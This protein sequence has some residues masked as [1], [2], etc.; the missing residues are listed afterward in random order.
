MQVL[1][2]NPQKGLDWSFL[3]KMEA[4]LLADVVD[5]RQHT[6][7]WRNHTRT[8]R[9]W[10]RKCIG[11]VHKA[12]PRKH[13]EHSSSSSSKHCPR[14]ARLKI[15]K[16]KL[17][18]FACGDHSKP[19]LISNYFFFARFGLKVSSHKFTQF[20]PSK[21]LFDSRNASH[22]YDLHDRLRKCYTANLWSVIIA[23]FVNELF[24]G[25]CRVQYKEFRVI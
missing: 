6:I 9:C 14:D 23:R 19:S 12:T 15:V 25:S 3:L 8:I 18:N 4:E 10:H 11:R 5:D 17:N 22:Q 21:P 1:S 7:P 24:I 13:G 2:R 16:R 20:L